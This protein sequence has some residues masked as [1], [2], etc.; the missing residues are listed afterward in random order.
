MYRSQRRCNFTRLAHHSASESMLTL[1]CAQY[2]QHAK[3]VN[4]DLPTVPTLFLLVDYPPAPGEPARIAVP[5]DPAC[6]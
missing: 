5:S 2:V 6:R 4:V 3:E 1:V